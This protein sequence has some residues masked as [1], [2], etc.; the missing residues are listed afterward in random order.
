MGGQGHTQH[1]FART[2]DRVKVTRRHHPLRGLDFEVLKD[3]RRCLCIRLRDGTPMR[4]PRR[5]TDAD[6]RPPALGDA[7]EA[8]F[9]VES[10]RHLEMLADALLRRR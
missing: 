5:W 9:T 8:V 6:D 10:L 2:P 7:A 1:I 3:G 4:I